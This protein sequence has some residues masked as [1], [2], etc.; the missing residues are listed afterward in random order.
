MKQKNN[1]YL[2][3]EQIQ[4]ET[5]TL[6]DEQGLSHGVMKTTDAQFIAY[7]RNI[8][9]V[10]VSHD[11]KN[12]ICK[13]M[14][15]NKFRFDQNK[16]IKEQKKNQKVITTKEVQVSMGIDKHDLETK[17]KNARKFLTSG[18]RVY[19][20]MRLRGR[21]NTMPQRGI[22]ILNNFF[23]MCNDVG[24]LSKPILAQ[25]NIISMTITPI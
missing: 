22:D 20:S 5:V 18:N 21:E 16:K 2:V 11:N 1:T 24:T 14:D 3:N 15:Y 12:P 13:L 17:V 7:E 23:E 6:I 10:L 19:V 4:F 8:D 9:L 25:G